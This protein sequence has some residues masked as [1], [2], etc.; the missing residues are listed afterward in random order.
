MRTVLG[1]IMIATLTLVGCTREE[2]PEPPTF[3]QRLRD[4]ALSSDLVPAGLVFI[5]DA[6]AVVG[7]VEHGEDRW[8]V[9]GEEGFADRDIEQWRGLLR[10]ATPAQLD[11]S[12]LAA[13]IGERD[14]DDPSGLLLAVGPDSPPLTVTG[15]GGGFSEARYSLGD[16][17]LDSADGFATLDGV[18]FAWALA[19]ALG[20]PRVVGLSINDDALVMTARQPESTAD[21]TV[22]LDAS[23]LTAAYA[24]QSASTVLH[25]RLSGV[26]G[27]LERMTAAQETTG[28]PTRIALELVAAQSPAAAL[29]LW[30]PDG[31]RAVAVTDDTAAVD[32]LNDAAAWD[33]TWPKNPLQGWGLADGTGETGRYEMADGTALTVRHETSEDALLPPATATGRVWCSDLDWDAPCW[34]ALSDGTRLIVDLDVSPFADWRKTRAT[35]AQLLEEIY[36][37]G[38]A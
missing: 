37:A 2:T 22:S 6:A 18:R 38:S 24:P 16:A 28:A 4:T 21:L 31:S 19:E 36:A 20:S 9:E 10:L 34:L 13:A 25:P 26:D 35:A 5:G 32:A 30:G 15:C 11:A 12:T 14:C 1:L 8:H 7:S 3:E 29:R 27:V 23:G 33:G 17:K